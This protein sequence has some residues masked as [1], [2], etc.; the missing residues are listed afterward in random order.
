MS[1]K[2]ILLVE[3]NEQDEG[4]MLRA[5]R[6][7]NISNETV[8]V[9]DGAE[10][11]DYLFATGKYADRNPAELPTVV[12]LD[13]KLPRVNGLEVLRRV[14]AN[15]HT[16]LLPIVVLTSSREE[17]DRLVGYSNGANSFVRKPIESAEFT[18]AIRQL[19]LYWLIV[20][21]PPPQSP[22]S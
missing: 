9:R 7:N 20:N 13:I 18:E 3:D 6:K 12:L 22:R 4:L 19:G 1:D 11:L 21:E 2:V 15:E 5:L 10:A 14:R 17:S 8:V 16:K